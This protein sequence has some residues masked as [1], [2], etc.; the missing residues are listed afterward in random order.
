MKYKYDPFRTGKIRY[1]FLAI[2]VFTGVLFIVPFYW[3]IINS[4][5]PNSSLLKL[6]P[7][8]FLKEPI[9]SKLI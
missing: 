1:V 2:S 7:P 3:M 6:P 4:L 8:L 9:F 5:M